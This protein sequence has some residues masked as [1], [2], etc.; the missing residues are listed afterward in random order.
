MKYFL[1][2]SILAIFII[3]TGIFVT[4]RND[5]DGTVSINLANFAV[6][7]AQAKFS[8]CAWV[9][10]LARYENFNGDRGISCL[11]D[12]ITSN[13]WEE[14]NEF[15]DWLYNEARKQTRF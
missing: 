4:Q 2:I 10:E 3:Y 8:Y 5:S 6:Q 7:K 1:V 12:C 14:V 13:K 9:C 15:G 11:D